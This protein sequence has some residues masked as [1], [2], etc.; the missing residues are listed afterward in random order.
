M[1]GTPDFTVG[2]SGGTPDA[3]VDDTDFLSEAEGSALV[4]GHSAA[5][6]PHTGY[7]RESLVDAKG[8]LIIA[9]SNDTPARHA[10]GNDGE[11]LIWDASATDGVRNSPLDEAKA[12]NNLLGW[13]FDVGAIQANNALVAATLYV[14]KIPL[15]RRISVTNVSA[16][17]GVVG[18]TLTNAF[19]LLYNS[20]GTVV[21]QSA[22]QSADWAAAIGLKTVA[23]A[24]GPFVCTPTQANDFLW[25]AIYVGTLGTAPQFGRSNKAVSAET[26]NVGTTAATSRAATIAIADTAT[27]GNITPANLVA[28]Q[29]LFWLGLT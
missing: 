22:D 25:G 11:T 27:P 9:T 16:Y 7:L 20:A 15:R 10:A 21:G 8:D 26:F 6:D 12:Y 19:L 24:G 3:S 13:T 5:S 17:L 29:N 14:A 23:L 2:D 28:G 1:A 18:V 4:A